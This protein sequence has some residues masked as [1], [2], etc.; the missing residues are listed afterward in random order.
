MTGFSLS[1]V[2]KMCAAWFIGLFRIIHKA[3]LFAIS[4]NI[5]HYQKIMKV[6]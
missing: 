5:I 4:Q 6:V 1:A 3:G 2:L